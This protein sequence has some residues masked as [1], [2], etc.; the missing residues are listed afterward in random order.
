MDFGRGWRLGDEWRRT[1]EMPGGLETLH[2]PLSLSSRR[3]GL[4]RPIIQ[5]FVRTM[6]GAGQNVA[7]GRAVGSEFIGDQK[8]AHGLTVQKLLHQTLG[9]LDIAAA[10]HKHFEYEAILID[11]S[12]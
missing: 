7:L 6:F 3:M 11:S 12:P 9:S 4:L 10:L 2:D 8:L 1:R 5:A